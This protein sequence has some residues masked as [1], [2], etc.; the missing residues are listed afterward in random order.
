MISEAIPCCWQAIGLDEGVMAQSGLE[1]PIGGLDT[2][3]GRGSLETKL[4][5]QRLQLAVWR[6]IVAVWK[7][8]VA[9][10]KPKLA[11]WRPKVAVWSD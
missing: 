3:V 10:Q 11:L 7:L 8:K 6:P 5:F 4:A 1:V 2:H 9:L